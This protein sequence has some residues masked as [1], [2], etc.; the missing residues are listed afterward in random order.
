[1][2]YTEHACCDKEEHPTVVTLWEAS[3]CG[4]GGSRRCL[5]TYVH[6]R[7]SHLLCCN[8]SKGVCTERINVS[9]LNHVLI[10]MVR[11]EGKRQGGP[12]SQNPDDVV[13]PRADNHPWIA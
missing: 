1:M 4:P 3:G 12:D 6:T 7:I 2:S 11:I 9:Q 13:S 5:N 10:A 8:R